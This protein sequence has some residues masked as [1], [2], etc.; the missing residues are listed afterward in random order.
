MCA[1][2]QEGAGF[3]NKPHPASFWCIS[4]VTVAS[5]M[6]AGCG[7]AC[8]PSDSSHWCGDGLILPSPVPYMGDSEMM[9]EG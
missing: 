6:A 5:A 4:T 9:Q 8:S 7:Q 1:L 3:I 2:Y